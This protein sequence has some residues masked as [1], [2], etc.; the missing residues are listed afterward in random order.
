[1]K[2]PDKVKRKI[3]LCSFIVTLSASTL[4][5][6]NIDSYKTYMGIDLEARVAPFQAGYGDNL[7][8][9]ELLQQNYYFGVM[10]NPNWGIELGAQY[11]SFKNNSV[12]INPGQQGLNYTIQKN[13]PSETNI[14]SST[15][16]DLYTDI[17]F[18]YPTPFIE[19]L[20]LTAAIGGVY[21]SIFLKETPSM[22]NGIFQNQAVIAQ[23][24]RTFKSRKFIP[25]ISLGTRYFLID[26]LG[27]RLLFEW[28]NMSRF[29]NVKSQESPTAV[30][31]ARLKDH[32]GFAIG[33]LYQF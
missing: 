6:A 1:M 8:K 24:T 5:V 32:Y 14:Y 28:E 26:N 17:Q 29:N 30:S 15:Y 12:T 16:K 10:F 4:S 21:K 25:R 2:L 20:E 7:F 22:V 18:F 23:Y 9:K 3:Q 27:I 11:A 31:E 19:D 13:D 33:L